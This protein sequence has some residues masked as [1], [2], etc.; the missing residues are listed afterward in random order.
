MF[1]QTIFCG[2]SL[3]IVS[4]YKDLTKIFI[5]LVYNSFNTDRYILIATIMKLQLNFR[6]GGTKSFFREEIVNTFRE[7]KTKKGKARP[8]R[9]VNL[10]LVTLYFVILYL[11]TLH[12]VIL[13]LVIL[14]LVNLYIYLVIL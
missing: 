8:M 6:A 7:G 13:Y 4:F 2:V 9:L 10:Y 12:L 3:D 1:R 14:Y 5:M 11:V